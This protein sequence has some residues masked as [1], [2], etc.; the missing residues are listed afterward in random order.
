VF[1]SLRVPLRAISHDGVEFALPDVPRFTR[2][3]AL[4]KTADLGKA[5]ADT[6]GDA[7]GCLIPQHG[8]VTVG[9]DIAS[10]VM[11][12]MLLGR[13]CAMQLSAMSA[14]GP[15]LWSSDEELR[16]KRDEIW[17]L[18][19]LRSGYQYLLRTAEQPDG[20]SDRTQSDNSSREFDA[21]RA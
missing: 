7:P 10:A 20:A 16:K 4:I 3:G 19:S 13:A 2:T 14:G 15:T 18:A 21:A 5:L 6:L 11:R 9:P 1:A 12:A 8:L 17:S